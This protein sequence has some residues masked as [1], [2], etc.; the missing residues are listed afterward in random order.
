[1]GAR[2]CRGTGR[3]ESP[4]AKEE[5]AAGTPGGDPAAAAAAFSARPHILAES[6]RAR[7]GRGAAPDV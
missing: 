6:P 7:R 1:V 3:A 2:R 4:D 5:M